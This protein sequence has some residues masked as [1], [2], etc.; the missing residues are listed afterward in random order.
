MSDW[1]SRAVDQT[2]P[3]T[4]SRNAI[5]AQKSSGVEQ[6]PYQTLPSLPIKVASVSDDVPGMP[7]LMDTVPGAGQSNWRTRAAPIQ[8]ETVQ[9][10]WKNRA[11]PAETTFGERVKQ[12]YAKRED[13]ISNIRAN[14]QNQSAAETLYQ[15]TMATASQ[16]FVDPVTEAI[17]TVTPDI[18]K[19]GIS[20]AV[21]LAGKIPAGNGRTIGE[22]IPEQIDLFSKEYPRA[23]RNIKATGQAANLLA[24]TTGVA[25][26]AKGLRGLVNESS[27]AAF[28]KS[29]TPKLE[30]PNIP[31]SAAEAAGVAGQNYDLAQYLGAKFSSDQVADQFE[32]ALKRMSPKPLANGKFTSEQQKFASSLKEFEGHAGKE[33]SLE[34]VDNLNKSLN[35]KINNHIDTRTGAPDADGMELM[36]L[37]TKLRN[38]VDAVPDTPG[39]D[40]LMNGRN[41][42]RAK[43]MM[44]DLELVAD[45]ASVAPGDKAKAMQA[46]YRALY[47]DQDRINSWPKEAKAALKVAAT[48][49]ISDEVLSTIT[50]RLPALV[51]LGTGNIAGAAGAQLGRIAG[52]GVKESILAKR[53]VKVQ[54]AIGKDLMSKLRDVDVPAPQYPE[55]L[56][57]AAPDKMSRLP[58]TEKQIGI[59]QKLMSRKNSLP[60]GEVISDTA[61]KKL[62][63]PGNVSNL[64]MSEDQIGIAQKLMSREPDVTETPNKFYG[65]IRK[66]NSF[67]HVTPFADQLKSGVKKFLKDEGGSVDPKDAIK[68]SKIAG[69]VFYHGGKNLTTSGVGVTFLTEDRGRAQF[70]ANGA[71]DLSRQNSK[72]KGKVTSAAVNIKNPASEK[73]V[74]SEAKKLGMKDLFD[75]SVDDPKS[76]YTNNA[77]KLFQDITGDENRLIERLKSLGYDG[78]TFSDAGSDALV[79]FDRKNIKPI[80][81][82]K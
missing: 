42:W 38:L 47:N 82:K 23:T 19:E 1:K 52:E 40:A 13:E 2:D 59:A 68:A 50:S 30:G 72:I 62:P 80:K 17:S 61:M 12:N 77:G 56:L 75:R 54:Q 21:H 46:G 49:G 66:P 8:A 14:A 44:Q 33:L 69:K 10:G 70:F 51:G 71:G 79:V 20:G 81:E 53:G 16:L 58:M 37:Q 26:S 25:N 35:Q 6:N 76:M 48:P 65:G 32:G 60:S 67:G 57:L 29:T 45:R 36:K 31:G 18:V 43:I 74:R 24:T 34:D 55:Q 39:N 7:N 15:G 3:T 41:A 63:S 64:P 22:V 4:A 78:A 73:I 11:Q 27:D 5:L 28:I 9:S